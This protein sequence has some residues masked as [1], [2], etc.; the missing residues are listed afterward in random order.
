MDNGGMRINFSPSGLMRPRQVVILAGG[1]GT[2][3]A[4]LTDA[5]PKPMIPFHGRPF[6]EYLIGYFRDNSFD[7][8]LLLLGYLPNAVREYFGDG[9]RFGMKIEYSIT[10]IDNDTGR[11]LYLARDLIEP[12]FLLAYCDNYCPLNFDAMWRRFRQ[13]DASAMVTVYANEDHY[14][15]DNLRVD[16]AGFVTTYDKSRTTPGLRGVDIGF[17][18]T[19]RE[20][21]DLLPDE[22]VSFETVAYPQ[23]IA[24]RQLL[25]YVTRHRYYSVGSH[26]RLKL[27]EDF[28]ARRP[29]IILDRD[30]VLNRRM[31]RAEYV[32][33][34]TDWTWLPG[35]LTALKRLKDA[36]WRIVII[37]NQPGIA[38]GLMTEAQ[39]ADIHAHMREAIVAAGGEISAIYHCPHGWDEG[40][41][42]RKPQ[43]GMLFQAQRDLNLD[44]SR[45]PFFGD[46]ERDGEAA[47]AAGSPF[48]MIN[49]ENSLVT[50][51]EKLLRQFDLDPR[52]GA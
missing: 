51:T 52:G 18:M 4:P 39:L 11:R 19:R 2:R 36:G 27:T 8:I 26:A 5:R 24:Q 32:R 16:D 14:T 34:W 1:R 13:G 30:G 7:R 37:T 44:L 48:V 25:S 22:N 17:M 15:R 20:A 33:N 10:D 49:E 12:T 46:D 29:T 6:L 28:L 41:A 21:I 47:V 50:A 23:L 31:P 35:T 40:C 45:T 38:R 42:C 43:P 3:L 9:S